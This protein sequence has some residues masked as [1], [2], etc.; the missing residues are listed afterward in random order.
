MSDEALS[1]NRVRLREVLAQLPDYKPGK[2][3]TAPPGVTAYKLSSNENPYG[4]LPSV[5]KAVDEA[6]TTINRYPDMAVSALTQRL[7]EALDVPAECIAT[8][9]G[10]VAVLAQVVQAA[11]D[12]GDEV[13]FAW[14]SFEAY[15]IVAQLAGAKPIM[16]GL[17]ADARHR[18]DAMAAAITDRTRVVLVCTPNNPTGPAVHG[19]ELERFLARVPDDVVVVVDEAYVEFVRDPE[20]VKGL[21]VWRKHPNVVVLRTFSKAYGLAGLRVGFAV[22]HPPVAAAIRKTATPFGVNSL[23]QVA[24]IASLDA[25]DELTERVESIVAERDRVVQALADQGWKLPRTDA[26]FVWFPLGEQSSAFSGACEAVGLMVRQY[27]D[28]GVRVTIG[29]SEANTRLLE[30]TEKF[31]AR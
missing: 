6:A 23:A 19:D 17:D 11:C 28:D 5:L 3:A 13:V 22:A 20:A 9:T 2:P 4:P 18:L 30:V 1:P 15:P 27:G 26:N 14:R 29:E 21:E 8:G 16:V 7:A 10:S 12:A 31:G 24:A 25:V